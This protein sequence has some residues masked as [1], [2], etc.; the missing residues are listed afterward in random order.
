MEIEK[1]IKIVAEVVRR[2]AKTRSD[3]AVIDLEQKL[4]RS[5]EEREAWEEMKAAD[6]SCSVL[7]MSFAIAHLARLYRS[8]HGRLTGDSFFQNLETVFRQKH[9][10]TWLISCK[11]PLA[12]LNKTSNDS[13]RAVLRGIDMSSKCDYYLVIAISSSDDAILEL[14]C[15]HETYDSNFVDLAKTGV[16][17]R[18]NEP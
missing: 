2:D 16:L 8:Q 17:V 7:A 6:S 3:K 15:Q 13:A 10:K 14:L 5:Q 4:F 11:K 1:H 12:E 18:L 9:M